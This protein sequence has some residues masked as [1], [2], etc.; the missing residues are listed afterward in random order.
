VALVVKSSRV[1]QRFLE[2]LGVA[3]ATLQVRVMEALEAQILVVAGLVHIQQ[4]MQT[5]IPAVLAV[6]DLWL[7]PIQTP[8]QIC[9]LLV[10][11]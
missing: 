6:L 7:L 5:V 9:H 4:M 2:G 11:V 10:L 8:M 1:D 3:E